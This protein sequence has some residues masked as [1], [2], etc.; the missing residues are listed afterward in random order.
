MLVNISE[1]LFK[2]L[3]TNGI[4]LCVIGLCMLVDYPTEHYWEDNKRWFVKLCFSATTL[5]V[6]LLW[7]L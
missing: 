2:L 1:V 5:T 3:L 7:S 4:I 6:A